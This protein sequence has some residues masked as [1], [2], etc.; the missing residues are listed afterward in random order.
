MLE[1]NR[2]NIDLFDGKIFYGAYVCEQSVYAP[3]G[4]FSFYENEKKTTIISVP[5]STI[6]ELRFYNYHN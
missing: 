5:L 3:N 1:F 6:K 4:F 2:I